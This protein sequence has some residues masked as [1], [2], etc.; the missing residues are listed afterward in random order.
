MA[1]RAYEPARRNRRRRWL[2][3]VLTL[4]AVIA[5]IAFLVSRQT[6]QRGT[7]EFYAAADSSSMLHD[8]ASDTLNAALERIGEDQEE[9]AGSDLPSEITEAVRKQRA[10]KR[11]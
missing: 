5:A 9:K 10:T 8:S 2:L 6:E 4:V 1:Y 11:G 3:I 7:V